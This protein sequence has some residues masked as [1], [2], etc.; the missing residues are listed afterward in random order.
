MRKGFKIWTESTATSPSGRHMGHYK[1]LVQDDNMAEFCITLME[2]PLQFGFASTR[3]VKSL[4]TRLPKDPDM[5]KV[6]RLRVIHLFETEYSFVLRIIW[7][8]RLLW[9]AQQFGIYI[10]A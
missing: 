6:E 10:P 8:R 2:L 5:K 3:W 1:A 4:Q 9:N 7:G